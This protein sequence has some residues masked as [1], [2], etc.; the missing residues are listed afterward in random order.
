MMAKR[1]RYNKRET[2]M[3]N[4]YINNDIDIL[5][6]L[7]IQGLI[8]HKM[9]LI[10]PAPQKLEKMNNVFPA[11]PHDE[12]YYFT[13]KTPKPDGSEN[14][15]PLFWSLQTIQSKS[16]LW[17]IT[18]ALI[19]RTIEKLG[20]EFDHTVGVPEGAT[21]TA[22]A[23]AYEM[24]KGVLTLRKQPKDHG[25]GG[26]LVGDLGI[27]DRVLVMEDVTT[28]G[29][30]MLDTA[31]KMRKAMGN[32]HVTDALVLLKR[33]EAP[34]VNLAKGF[35]E[36]KDE[37]TRQMVVA[38]PDNPYPI[39]LHHVITPD[40]AIPHWNPTD[41]WQ[42]KMKPVILEYLANQKQKAK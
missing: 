6:G 41:P 23:V 1:E 9:L 33:S 3:A 27:Q 38:N 30:S 22:A 32:D 5:K 29:M 34:V 10:A 8:Y 24:N 19:V 26:M 28:T 14:L 18:V 25:Q 31:L 36:V 13:L 42:I 35:H 20:L 39:K 7:F 16:Q 12:R 2:A 11:D 37:E 40:D 15:S 17:Q 21:A 4:K